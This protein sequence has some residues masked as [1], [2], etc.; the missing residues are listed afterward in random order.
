MPATGNRHPLPSSANLISFFPAPSSTAVFIPT[1]TAPRKPIRL[2]KNTNNGTPG[3]R[4][5]PYPNR[6][7]FDLCFQ[8]Q[9]APANVDNWHIHF[10]V[11][12]KQDPSL[13]LSLSNYWVINQKAKTGLVKHFGKD[14]EANLLL[15]L[16]YAACIPNS[17]RD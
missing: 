12:S 8:L 5:N 3:K 1:V 10:L 17:G 6:Y 15:N 13:K 7:P 2:W 4:N 9:E 11:A 16:G 14:F